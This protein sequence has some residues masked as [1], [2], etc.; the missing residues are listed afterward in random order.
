MVVLMKLQKIALILISVCAQMT[1]TSTLLGENA[2]GHSGCL[3]TGAV[4]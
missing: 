1:L 4:T 3:G 2:S